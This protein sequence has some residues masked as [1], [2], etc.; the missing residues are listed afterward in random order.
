[1]RKIIVAAVLLFA[2]PAYAQTP[3]SPSELALGQKLMEEIN[4][5]I[6]LRTTLIQAQAEVKRLQAEIDK[7]KKEDDE[8]AVKK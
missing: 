4:Q 2:S 3:Q 1:M 5:N 6:Q 8:K 7:R